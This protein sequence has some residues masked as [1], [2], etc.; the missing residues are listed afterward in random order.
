MAGRKVFVCLLAT[1][2]PNKPNLVNRLYPQKG[3]G[4]G[5]KSQARG[6]FRYGTSGHTIKT[7]RI[8]GESL[9]N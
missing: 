9:A 1:I 2:L 6:S 3:V 4:V 5:P 8:L 7:F